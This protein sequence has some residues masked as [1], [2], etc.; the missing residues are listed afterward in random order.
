MDGIECKGQAIECTECGETFYLSGEEE[1]WFSKMGF[2][3][4]K[5]CRLCR[6]QSHRKQVI[7]GAQTTDTEFERIMKAAKAEISR[8]RRLEII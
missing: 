4:P 7:D 6:K 2:Q 5:R 8:W 3:K 1:A